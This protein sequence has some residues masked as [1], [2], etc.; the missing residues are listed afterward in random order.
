MSTQ[1]TLRCVLALLVA[2]T[3]ALAAGLL[4]WGPISPGSHQYAD[5]RALGGIPG[6]INALAALPLVLVALSGIAALRRSSWPT[7]VVRPWRLFFVA[8]GGASLLAALYH[9]L[10]GDIG[11]VL[12]NLLMAAAFTLL[13]A[14]FLAERAHP[15]FGSR[16]AC[17]IALLLPVLAALWSLLADASRGLPDLRGLLLLQVLPVLLVPA[18]AL[19][20]P[21]RVTSA[22]DWL[23]MLVLYAFAKLLEAADATVYAAT[24]WISGHSLMHL[25]L[26]GVALWLAYRALADVPATAGD[27]SAAGEA[28]QRVS[29]AS[30]SG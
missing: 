14:G 23:L 20:L 24:G 2:M 7:E 13:L 10:P 6:V 15:Q 12:A 5:M 11:Y 22:G 18:G 29:S 28:S 17:A 19:S 25:A 4:A 8:A 26:A 16:S 27:G 9:L 30:T 1:L 3:A 21:G